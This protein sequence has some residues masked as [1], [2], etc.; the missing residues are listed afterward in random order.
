MELFPISCAQSL[1]Q[2]K[3]VPYR[4]PK[5]YPCCVFPFAIW[6]N[7]YINSHNILLLGASQ[8]NS[9]LA[10]VV[11]RVVSSEESITKNDKGSYRLGEVHTLEGRDTAALDLEDVVRGGE[12]VVGSSEVE[13]DIGE[14]LDLAALDGVLA[15]VTL[16]GTNLLVQELSEGAG[17]DVERGTSVKDGTSVLLLS[18]LITEGNGLKINLPVSLTAE[19]N[20]LDISSVLGLI[21]ATEGSLTLTLLAIKVKGEDRLVQELLVDHLVE[22]RDHAVHSNTVIAETEDTVEATEG[23]SQAGL[24][25]CL[26]KVL[27]LD[28]EVANLHDIVGDETRQAARSVVDFELAAVGLVSR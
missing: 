23:E 27:I 15:V 10:E 20:V 6:N 19:G 7:S 18:D 2:F 28:L 13:G 9:V 21:N 24:L 4:C 8:T 22:G 17:E 5:P 16:L 3:L 12:A 26:S 14:L 25:R 1:I 11:D